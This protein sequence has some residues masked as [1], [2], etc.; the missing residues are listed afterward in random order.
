MMWFV[1]FM[2]KRPSDLTIR[3]GRVIFGLVLVWVLYYN[4][5]VQ[6]DKIDNNFFWVDLDPQIVEYIKYFFVWI[7]IIPILMWLF[8]LCLFK[9]K[10][11]RIIQ[12]VFGVMLFYIANQILPLNPD[13][14]DVDVLVG[15]MW[16]L[17]LLAWITWKCITTKCM[18]YKEKITKIRV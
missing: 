13:D 9:K 10:Y 5:I 1:K 16:I 17:P 8:N 12:I 11:V 14:L 3:L 2:Q 18:K 6:G 4:L 7:W 15:F